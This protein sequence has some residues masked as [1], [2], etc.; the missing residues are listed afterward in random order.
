M[1]RPSEVASTPKRFFDTELTVVQI[2]GEKILCFSPNSVPLELSVSAICL[3]LRGKDT[4]EEHV[5][6]DSF[7]SW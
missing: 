2:G 6:G 1:G 3:N 5:L 4:S 7:E